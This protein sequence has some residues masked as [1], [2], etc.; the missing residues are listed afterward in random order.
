MKIKIL[1]LFSLFFLLQYSCLDTQIVNRMAKDE[2]GNFL[3]IGR[4]SR[5]AFKHEAYSNWFQD[6]YSAYTPNKAITSKLKRSIKK[7]KIVIFYGSWCE[8]SRRELPRFLKIMDELKMPKNQIEIYAVDRRK[9][10][11]FGEEQG[12]NITKVPTFIFYKKN[13]ISSNKRDVEI[14]RIIENPMGE[15]LE[16]DILKIVNNENYTPKYYY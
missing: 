4:Q 8:D 2:E 1:V 5:D 12:K 15:S 13:K 16:E 9:E 6:E 3:M 14:N 11:F 7:Y 10:S